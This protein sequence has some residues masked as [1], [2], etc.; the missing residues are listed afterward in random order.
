[1]NSTTSIAEASASAELSV[2]LA[3]LFDLNPR[4]IPLAGQS[5]V[6]ASG[7]CT[8]DGCTRSCV[9]CGCR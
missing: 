7:D 2:D 6:A 1:M 3:D 9:S 4:T 5:T 8:N